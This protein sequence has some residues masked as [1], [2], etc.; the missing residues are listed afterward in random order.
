MTAQLMRN[1]QDTSDLAARVRDAIARFQA[2]PPEVQEMHRWAQK[3]NYVYGE[4]GFDIDDNPREHPMPKEQVARLVLTNSVGPAY[5]ENRLADPEF[6]A[7][8]G[9]D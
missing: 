8:L 6:R 3:I 5:A 2:L 9:L 7:L 4:L 1:R